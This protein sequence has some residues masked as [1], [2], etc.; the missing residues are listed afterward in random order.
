MPKRKSRQGR[1]RKDKLHIPHTVEK[2]QKSFGSQLRRALND[3]NDEARTKTE[4]PKSEREHIKELAEA[5][6]EYMAEKDLTKPGGSWQDYILLSTLRRVYQQ[7]AVEELALKTGE[8]ERMADLKVVYENLPPE[9]TASEEEIDKI[10]ATLKK[11]K[12]AYEDITYKELVAEIA[13]LRGVNIDLSTLKQRNVLD[14]VD[15]IVDSVVKRHER[16][17]WILLI[18]G[19]LIGLVSNGLFEL[20]KSSLASLI[21]RA[22]YAEAQIYEVECDVFRAFND[23]RPSEEYTNEFEEQEITIMLIY[24]FHAVC[25]LS[26]LGITVPRNVLSW[27][28]HSSDAT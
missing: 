19:I 12:P 17:K 9:I 4:A 1:K 25:V 8:N 22:P 24:T 6:Y 23:W 10:I 26:V 27:M 21:A 3:P 18:E 28:L 20:L 11:Q 7:S 13:K 15:K 16:N 5:I 2:A 14:E